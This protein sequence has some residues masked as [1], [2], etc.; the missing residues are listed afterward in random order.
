MTQ[1][2]KQLRSIAEPR[3]VG[4][5]DDVELEVAKMKFIKLKVALE[6]EMQQHAAAGIPPSASKLRRLAMQM[7]QFPVP[8]GSFAP[9]LNMMEMYARLSSTRIAAAARMCITARV[10]VFTRILMATMQVQLDARHAARPRRNHAS[11][12]HNAVT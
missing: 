3:D 7:L 6:E 5:L 4:V 12:C 8:K 11:L 2:V 10:V 1:R 9:C